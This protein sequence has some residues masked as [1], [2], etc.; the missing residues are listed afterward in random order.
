[1]GGKI[2]KLSLKEYRW[3]DDIS[4]GQNETGFEVVNSSGLE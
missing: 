1:M 3:E 2:L 4:M